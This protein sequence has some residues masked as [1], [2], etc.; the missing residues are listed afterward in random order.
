MAFAGPWGVAVPSC[1]G[2]LNQ[3]ADLAALLDYALVSLEAHFQIKHSMILM[4]DRAGK[5]LYTV[6]SRG[7][8]QS[9]VGSEI[10]L[11]CG[12]IG[13]AAEQPAAIS[14]RSSPIVNCASTPSSGFPISQTTWK[15]VS[16]FFNAGSWSAALRNES[17]KRAEAASACRW[18]VPSP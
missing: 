8:R 16:S 5:R 17:K 18:L 6:G 13:V 7:Y 3:S 14:A 4:L 11:G 2:V 15:P 10:A 12:V 1:S 9:G